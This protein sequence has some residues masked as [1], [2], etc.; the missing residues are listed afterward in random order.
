MAKYRKVDVRRWRPDRVYECDNAELRTLVRALAYDALAIEYTPPYAMSTAAGHN[1]VPRQVDDAG[2]RAYCYFV[3]SWMGMAGIAGTER[4]KSKLSIRYTSTGGSPS[5]CFAAAVNSIPS[6]R[7][8]LARVRIL[9]RDGVAIIEKISDVEGVAIYC[10][11]PYLVSGAAYAHDF[12]DGDHAR[13]ATAL[14]RFRV[15]RVVVSYYDHPALAGLY[16]GWTTV[17]L[18]ARR[19]LVCQSARDMRGVDA[20]APEMLLLNGPSYAADPQAELF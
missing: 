6:W 13:L 8:R 5:V 10:D 17:R 1:Y 19:A 15:A 9:N 18:A 7:R 3:K 4:A 11:P 2:E 12:T 16:P 20:P 14:A